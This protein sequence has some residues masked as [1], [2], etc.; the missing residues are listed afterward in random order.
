MYLYKLAEPGT[1][2]YWTLIVFSL[3][4]NIAKYVLGA[5]GIERLAKNKGLEKT[6]MAWIPIVDLCLL[7]KIIERIRIGKWE[8]VHLEQLLPGVAVVTLAFCWIPVL[9]TIV[10]LVMM[11]IMAFAMY[12][13]FVKYRPEQ[14]ILYTIIG[15]VLKLSDLFI[16]I[17]RNDEEVQ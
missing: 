7:G 12:G 5:I 2:A 4:L 1:S 14:A 10:G 15:L 13:L 9:G 6:W 11:V 8:I 3:I 16:F 17:I